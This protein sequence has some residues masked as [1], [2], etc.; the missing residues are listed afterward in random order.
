MSFPFNYH[1]ATYSNTMD[2]K[3]YIFVKT[4]TLG[5]QLIA[6][7][8]RIQDPIFLKIVL[9]FSTV[10]IESFGYLVI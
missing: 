9:S 2:L 5:P 10:A 4:G 3:S 1:K 8:Y 6:C 7:T